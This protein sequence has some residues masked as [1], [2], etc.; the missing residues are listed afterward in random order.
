MFSPSSAF[1]KWAPVHRDQ[2]DEAQGQTSDGILMALT[3]GL[4]ETLL[5][6]NPDLHVQELEHRPQRCLTSP[7]PE[8]GGR[9]NSDGELVMYV[10]DQLCEGG[11]TR[12]TVLDMLGKGTFGQ[13]VLC[14]VDGSSRQVAVKVIKNKEAYWKQAQ[15]EV[16]ILKWINETVDP[17]DQ[18][19]IVRMLDSFTARAHLCIVFEL[20]S[21]S[22]LDLLQQNGWKGVSTNLI[23]V[24]MCQLVDAF[25][26]LWDA[27]LVHCDL[28]PENIL[29]HNTQGNW[30]IKLVDFGSSCYAGRTVYTYIQSRFYRSPEVVLG[31]AYTALIDIW[32]LGC[33]AMELLLG[34]PLYSAS[35]EFDLLLRIASM[36][37][38]LDPQLLHSA[39][40]TKQAEFCTLEHREWRL[41]TEDEYSTT[42][43]FTPGKH[44]YPKD[45]SLHD[46][47]LGAP[48]TPKTSVTQEE[49]PQRSLSGEELLGRASLE[50]F[51]S[52]MVAVEISSR[53]TPRQIAT[54][55][56]LT[57]A[58]FDGFC[59]PEPDIT[60]PCMQ[61]LQSTPMA[62]PG[63]MS[64]S[65]V[66]DPTWCDFYPSQA[67]GGSMC[68]SFGSS[69]DTYNPSYF[70]PAEAWSN[71]N[72]AG[73]WGSEHAWGNTTQEQPVQEQRGNKKPLHHRRTSS[74]DGFLTDMPLPSQLEAQQRKKKKS[75]KPRR[76]KGHRR[77]WSRDSQGSD[78][79]KDD[80]KFGRGS[81]DT[82]VSGGLRDSEPRRGKGHRRNW[83]RDSQGSDVSKDDFKFGR[84]STDT[85]V[86]GGLRDSEPRRGKGHRR[87][88]SRDRQGSDVSKDDFKFGRGSTDT[89]VSGGLRDSEPRRG[90]GH[91][92]NW[93]RDSQG[94]D[95]SKDDFKFGRGS[96][97]T[98]VSGGLR[99]S[100][101]ARRGRGHRRN[102]S[103]SSLNSMD[104]QCSDMSKDDFKFG[105]G[106]TDSAASGQSRESA[107]AEVEEAPKKK[108][109]R[110]HRRMKS[111]DLPDMSQLMPQAASLDLNQ[112]QSCGALPAPVEQAH[113]EP[114]IELPKPRRRRGK[115]EAIDLRCDLTETN[116]TA[117]LGDGALPTSNEGG[118][119][120]DCTHSTVEYPPLQ[121]DRTQEELE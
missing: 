42:H 76:G 43:A 91:R 9:E 81:T 74:L 108:T 111:G 109:G 18:H 30:Q 45:S 69:W 44:H 90:K 71:N 94:S 80:F 99:D 62:I 86:S 20:L 104:S 35:C 51:V 16:G 55:P 73:S 15:V 56:F 59:F 117:L 98:V 14:S 114:K 17:L 38:K 63:L 1:E 6:C 88:W 89:V 49:E 75:G 78:V 25:V 11:G 28:K 12:Y 47:V 102:W 83:S 120:S 24:F 85:V 65:C 79:S 4:A 61:Q 92:R 52:C 8:G 10:G 53:W 3:K 100:E 48:P 41:L 70:P 87:N 7:R 110:R 60:H 96:T 107:P 57:G 115:R 72:Q 68:S 112:S 77:N 106:S 95:V 64:T 118:S 66:I 13:V 37:G 50:H 121:L 67:M 36:H 82:V 39:K 105:R 21:I 22:M 31:H 26:V 33:I 54:H 97:D 58:E 84:G 46:L 93:S 40:P 101:P 27:Q 5:Q 19:H 103:K 119:D 29:L 2:R 23:R 113:D 34:L 32:S 116:I